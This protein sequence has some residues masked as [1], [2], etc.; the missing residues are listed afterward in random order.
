MK[1]NRV[2][3]RF[4]TW[5][6]IEHNMWGSVNDRASYIEKAI[7]FTGDHKRYGAYMRAVIFQWPISCENALTDYSRNRKAWIGHAACAMAFGCPE[8][9]VRSAW[10]R[11]TDEQRTLANREAANAISIWESNYARHKGILSHL[12][13][14]LL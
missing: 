11:L 14:T 9:I 4:D 5:E 7:A 13:E 1:F 2:W 6:E 12:G 3:H 10:S 8:D